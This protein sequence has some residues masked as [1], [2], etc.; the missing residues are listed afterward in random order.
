[1]FLC[2]SLKIFIGHKKRRNVSNFKSPY[3]SL[4]RYIFKLLTHLKTIPSKS[5]ARL[6]GSMLFGLKL[7]L[8]FHKAAHRRNNFRGKFVTQKMFA[9]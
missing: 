9:I 2:P 7:S 1:M 3:Q 8:V 4:I 5:H 6:R